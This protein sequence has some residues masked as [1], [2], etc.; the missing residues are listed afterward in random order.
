MARYFIDRPIFAWVIAILV[1]LFG[2]LSIG[3][4]P[5]SQFPEIAPPSIAI[6]A[7]YPGA[8]A[9]TLE[10]TVTQVIEQQMKG[11][12]GLRY[13]SST[14]DSA[15]SVRI[16]LTF[17]QG[18]DPDI[19]QVQAQNKLQLATPLLPQEV[20]QQG[21]RVSKSTINF[22]TV[23]AVH[24]RDSSRTASDLG[25]IVASR[26]QDPLSRV[27]GVG[28]TM[29]LGAQYAMRVW[30]DPHKLN[31][32]GLTTADVKEAIRAQNAQVSAGQLGGQPSAPER[33]LNATVSAQSR[34][35]TPEAFRQIILRSNGD[36]SNVRL[37]DVARVEL[38][39]EMYDVTAKYNGRPSAGF[40]IRLAPG[41]NALDTMDAVKAEVDRLKTSLPDDID[42]AYPYDST[43]FVEHSVTQVVKTLLEAVVLVFLVM[44]L[45]LQNFRATLIPTIAVPVVL[46]GTFGVL[47]LFGF[48]I[49]TLT[50]FGMVLAIGLLVDDAIVVVENVER[51]MAEEGLSPLEA[52]RKSMG[53]ISGALVG[54]GL[55]LSA[56]F[57]P[58]A[59]FG[60]SAGVIYRQ[61]SITIVTA[62]ILSVLTAMILTPA[63]C[64]TLLKPVAKGSHGKT[65][66]FFGWFNRT[67]ERATVRYVDGVRRTIRSARRSFLLYAS[68][69]VVAVLLFAGLPTG[70]L[71]DE[72]QG[73]AIALVT[74]PPGATAPRTEAVNRAIT[75]HILAN[76][77]DSVKE[78]LTLSG[79]SFAG[80][81]QNMGMAFVSLKPWHERSGEAASAAAVAERLNAAMAAVRDARVIAF[82]PPAIIEL[83]NATGFDFQLQNEAGLPREQFLAARNQLLGTAAQD[84]ALMA[85]R[86]NGQEDT[87]QLKIEV[88]QAS[89]SA[90]G[91]SL[92]AVNDMIATAWGGSYVNDFI[93]RGRVK[94]VYVQADE[95]FRQTPEDLGAWHVRGAT[96]A[97]T[98][99]SAY[100]STHWTQ[101]PTRLERYNGVPSFQIL[102]E[103]A[104]GTSSGDAMAAM[105]A[106]AAKLPAGVGF[107]WSGLSYEERLA[108]NQALVMYALSILLVFLCLAALYESWSIPVAVILSAPLGIFGAL[109]TATAAGLYNDIY[110]QVAMLT[111]VGVSAKNA[112]LIVE[113]AEAER[114][115]GRPLA[116]AAV[117]AAR[118]RLRPILMTS[119]A[120]I[121]GLIPLAMSSGAGAGGQN[122]IGLTVVGGMFAATLLAVVFVPLFFVAVTR[123]FGRRG[124]TARA[125]PGPSPA[126]EPPLLPAPAE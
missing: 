35:S 62:M 95:P 40:A 100:G 81:G 36:G 28:D 84:P 117:H 93:D 104:P 124:K 109:M 1:M 56:V 71:P 89:A 14:S 22:L 82:I 13:M 2:A 12:D 39:S 74:L 88:D 34:L 19:A 43:P 85:V 31:S 108:G 66:G 37:S 101:G 46:L 47:A 91:L 94:K 123:L 45:F 70:F 9:Q 73:Q 112:I 11:L 6:D 21:V 67:F 78:V 30:L 79:F 92:A 115:A 7:N 55:V 97:M 59:F 102:G 25:D 38:G 110:F 23:L 126:P 111:V 77:K 65:T 125:E 53:E 50:L 41:A 44:L 54:I 51:I 48:S 5:V 52:T 29:V 18:T 103:P 106:I 42:I 121:G 113:F 4:L 63:L 10:N 72:D 105:E 57:V 8:S 120:F 118:L 27:T 114:K 119:F 17:E 90:H 60:G 16:T 75:E 87:P 83:G 68:L 80:R 15:G 49:N 26:I 24:S 58:M 69:A 3:R 61:F 20:Q 116:D 33:A 32:Y 64:A 76:E 96:G 107:E 122:A 86:P 99:F 98:P